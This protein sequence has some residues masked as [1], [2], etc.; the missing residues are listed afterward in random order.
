ME[1]GVHRER[2]GGESVL[3]EGVRVECGPK[4]LTLSPFRLY[5]VRLV[6]VIYFHF[7]HSTAH[8]VISG[9]FNVKKLYQVK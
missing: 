5:R 2:I 6:T 8:I 1:R 4:C 3:L 7:S 9:D